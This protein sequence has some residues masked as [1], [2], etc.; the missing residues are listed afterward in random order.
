MRFYFQF[1]ISELVIREK[2][3]GKIAFLLI[4]VKTIRAKY[5]ER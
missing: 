2:Q 3:Q 4:N 1:D 5:K